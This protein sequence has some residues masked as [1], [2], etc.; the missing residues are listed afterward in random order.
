MDAEVEPVRLISV[1]DRLKPTGV[2]LL[3]LSEL[4]TV[5]S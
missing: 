4:A 3:V 5:N 1:S 2:V